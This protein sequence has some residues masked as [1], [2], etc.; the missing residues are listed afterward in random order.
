MTVELATIV[1]ATPVVQSTAD[2]SAR[3]PTPLPD[4][5]VFNKG[6]GNTE[7]WDP[8]QGAWI[9]DAVVP[10][11]VAFSATPVFD[12]SGGDRDFELTLTGDV[13]APTLV[14]LIQ[15]ARVTFRLKQ[16][17]TGGRIFTWPANVKGGGQISAGAN[18]L[19]Q[20]SFAVARDGNAYAL[21]PML[22]GM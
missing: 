20:Q 6:T 12:A 14:T 1:E 9:A 13:T 15:G 5:R 3:F 7:R 21:A 4:Q 19:S 16:D 22:S 18:T 11:P 10:A 2:R 8:A 17:A